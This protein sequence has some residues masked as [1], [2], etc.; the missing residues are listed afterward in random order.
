MHRQLQ[1]KNFCN[2]LSSM[3]K[4]LRRCSPTLRYLMSPLKDFFCSGIVDV[5]LSDTRSS[6][7]KMASPSWAGLRSNHFEFFISS[8]ASL[9]NAASMPPAT[10]ASGE[11]MCDASLLFDHRRMCKSHAASTCCRAALLYC[12]PH[13][14]LRAFTQYIRKAAAFV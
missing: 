6:S 12:G 3:Q 9:P 2:D 1:R 10:V 11:G 5:L 13:E 4:K 7:M 14:A 8:H